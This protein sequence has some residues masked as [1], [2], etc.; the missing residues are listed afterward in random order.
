MNLLLILA[1]LAPPSPPITPEAQAI[2]T[3]ESGDT[4]TLGSANYTALFTY[5]DTPYIDVIKTT[6]RGSTN[7][8]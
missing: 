5:I 3:C 4:K 2:A 1:L 8:S 6:R 7:E